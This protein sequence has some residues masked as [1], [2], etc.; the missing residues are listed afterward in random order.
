MQELA[1]LGWMSS[2]LALLEFELKRISV[3]GKE[4]FGKQGL[5]QKKAWGLCVFDERGALEQS[6]LSRK[7][8][9]Q[10]KKL[11]ELLH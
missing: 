5:E 1:E 3:R 11:S 4:Q 8:E 7:R 10:M 2:K 9:A 6:K